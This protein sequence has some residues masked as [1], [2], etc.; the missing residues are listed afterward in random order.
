MSTLLAD[1]SLF[2][3]GFR[4]DRR[5][6]GLSRRDESG[7]FVPVAIGS[8]A[9]DVLG[10]LVARAGELVSRDDIIAAVW[11]ATVVE[12]N[13]LNIQIA[14]LRRVLDQGRAESCIRTIAG[15]GY[16]FVAPVTLCPSEPELPTATP[17]NSDGSLAG[18]D[19]APTGSEL[20][21]EPA[22]GG[23]P[24][25]V[26]PRRR[27]RANRGIVAGPAVMLMLA[28]AVAIVGW[29]APWFGGGGTAAP[30]LSIAVLP[31]ADLSPGHDQQYFADA[32]TEDLTT[33]LSHKIGVFV[34][35]AESALTYRGNP[36]SAKEIG[37]ELGVR[38]VVE[39]SVE[40]ADGRVRVNAQLIDAESDAHL[41][42]ERFDREFRDLFELQGEITGRIAIALNIEMVNAEAARPIGNPQAEDY[43]FRGR[44]AYFGRSP[45]RENYDEAIG[46]YERA[47]ALDPRS[48]AAK[49]YLAGALINRVFTFPTKAAPADFARAEKLIDEALAAGT[50]IPW[51]HYVKGSVLRT[52]GQWAAAIAEYEAALALDR[53][54]TGALQGIGWCELFTGALDE[55][56]PLAEK[57]IRIGPR[58]PSIGFRY[59]QIGEVRELQHRPDLAIGWFEKARA[60]MPN[61]AGGRAHLAADYALTGDP[62]RAAAELAAARRMNP[63]LYSILAGLK[64]STPWGVP[65]VEA[66]FEATYFAGLRK[67]GM[68]E[69]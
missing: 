61:Y 49:T 4:F 16:R 21:D 12:D 26:S 58:D 2:F 42:T 27:P 25:I 9:L 3:E 55:V 54:M 28:A 40:R 13:N 68:P 41:W 29:H 5:G 34:I 59:A 18:A 20:S 10:V 8:R 14:A 38:Y 56:I 44:E 69:E 11:P 64:A 60:A 50:R 62:E 24:L 53:N 17:Q 66:L 52:K 39:G 23:A 37:R 57:G 43:I 48:A 15:R 35:S 65:K 33:D 47:L 1:D 31:F 22:R 19:A 63:Y 32:V 36:K 45:A 67:A 6:G 7:V 51:A 30:R 46:W